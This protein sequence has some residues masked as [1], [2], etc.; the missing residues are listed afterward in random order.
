L[1]KVKQEDSVLKYGAFV[2]PLLDKSL[3]NCESPKLGRKAI[4]DAEI[5]TTPKSGAFVSPLIDKTLGKRSSRKTKANAENIV[6]RPLKFSFLDHEA[7]IAELL[8]KAFKVP[9]PDY[10]PE[11]SNKT[12]GIRKILVRRYVCNHIKY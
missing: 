11:Y 3:S 12:L 10:I 8:S 5:S 2:S 1:K 6:P 7:V 9:I 4:L